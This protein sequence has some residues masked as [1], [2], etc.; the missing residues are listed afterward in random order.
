[1]HNPPRHPTTHRTQAGRDAGEAGGRRSSPQ[2]ARG[3][4]R[5]QRWLLLLTYSAL[6]LV[7]ATLIGCDDDNTNQTTDANSDKE[8][9][10]PGP[11]ND[12]GYTYPDFGGTEAPD[13][14]TVDLPEYTG[15]DT[16]SSDTSSSSG[17]DAGTGPADAILLQDGVAPSDTGPIA[18][19][20]LT[21]VF[22]IK[23]PSTGS[24]SVQIDGAG[25]DRDT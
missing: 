9:N 17:S 7:P 3:L 25:F 11:E 8:V 12:A 10:G 15:Q 24:I 1:M 13:Q 20:L 14:L 6:L 23:G 5:W 19:V 18:E 21:S 22:P 2:Q 4:Q 16:G